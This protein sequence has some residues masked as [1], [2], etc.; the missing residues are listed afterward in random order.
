MERFF[1]EHLQLANHDA[2]ILCDFNKILAGGAFGDQRLNRLP[3]T[4]GISEQDIW[5]AISFFMLQSV[6]DSIEFVISNTP[7]WVE[8]VEDGYELISV[9]TLVQIY[10]DKTWS[11]F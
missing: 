7:R 5:D 6:G 1:G 9:V 4:E 11:G 8:L 10:R 2:R 3:G